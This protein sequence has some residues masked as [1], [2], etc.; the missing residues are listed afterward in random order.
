MSKQPSFSLPFRGS[1]FVF[2][3]GN[4]KAVNHHHGETAQRYALDLIMINKKSGSHAGSG[5]ENQDYYAFGQ[6]T[7]AP[8]GGEVI[9]AVDGFRD[10]EPQKTTNNYAYSGN[11]VMIKHAENLYSVLA[12]LR[13]GSVQVK[14]GE[15]VLAGQKLGECGNS[16]NS[17]EPH[18]HFHAQDN[19][20]LTI[21]TK[22]YE[23]K[24]FAK[25][26]K[27]Y[28]DVVIE[29]KSERK[30]KLHYSPIKGDILSSLNKKSSNA[31]L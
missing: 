7:L 29:N 18:L 16:G 28:F 19:S 26:V 27:A 6:D 14:A 23:R 9:E 24:P 13:H 22:D 15:K 20:V 21:L 1:W 5:S 2:C 3:G 12:H 4:T 25:G 11:F 17:T 10:N 8:A 30:R 31:A